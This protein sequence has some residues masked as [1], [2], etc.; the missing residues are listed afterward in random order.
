M[1]LVVLCFFSRAD[2]L[3]AGGWNRSSLRSAVSALPVSACA[4]TWGSVGTPG[5]QSRGVLAL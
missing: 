1:A 3:A 5:W 4:E 2:M